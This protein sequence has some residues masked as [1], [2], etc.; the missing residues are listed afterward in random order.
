MMWKLFVLILFLGL[1]LLQETSRGEEKHD[2]GQTTKNGRQVTQEVPYNLYGGTTDLELLFLKDMQKVKKAEKDPF[3]P[4]LELLEECTK[5]L[6]APDCSYN[7]GKEFACISKYK[8]CLQK[9]K[10]DN[11]QSLNKFFGCKVDFDKCRMEARKDY[12]FNCHDFAFESCRQ[13]KKRNYPSWV[14]GLCTKKNTGRWEGLVGHAMVIIAD[15]NAPKSM[16]PYYCIHEAQ[17]KELNRDLCE[18]VYLNERGKVQFSKKMYE[19]VKESIKDYAVLC[20]DRIEISEC[21]ESYYKCH[22][23]NPWW[24][25]SPDGKGVTDP[26]TIPRYSP[27]HGH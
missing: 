3:L 14:L 6:R 22:G 17:R 27:D 23:E 5:T 16:Q 24:I 25:C 15:V 9:D 2:S 13:L 19:K 8:H 4:S 11:L 1:C 21:D 7:L 18:T 12:K 26:T 20:E 10:S